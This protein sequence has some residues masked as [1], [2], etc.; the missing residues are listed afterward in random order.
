[1]SEK[2]KYE[3]ISASTAFLMVKTICRGNVGKYK[4]QFVPLVQGLQLTILRR[5]ISSQW[6]IYM[7]LVQA[8]V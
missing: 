8:H 5:K 1:M 2:A 4:K 3:A 6:E 7:M